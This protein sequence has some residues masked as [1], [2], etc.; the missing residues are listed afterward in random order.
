[1]AKKG[2]SDG[3]KAAYSLGFH[4]GSNVADHFTID[5]DFANLAADG[6]KEAL[7]KEEPQIPGP[8]ILAIV[9]ELQM[10]KQQEE[11]DRM[12]NT[13]QENLDLGKKFTEA[14][15]KSFHCTASGICYKTEKEGDG[16]AHPKATDRVTVHYHLTLPVCAI[17]SLIG[18]VVDSSI[19]RKEP[20]TFGL[21]QV[22]PGWTEMVQL[23]TVGQKVTCYIPPNLGYGERGSGPDIQGNQ[24]L[25]F[26][27]ELL[28]IN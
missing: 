2:F 7:L 27:I 25:C 3:E 8:E 20:A 4:V 28:K 9:Q 26:T 15:D 6:F 11:A 1:M 24:L 12:K 21:N 5:K 16:K 22:I 13:A 23:M 14:L 18:K 19:A 10:R 17:K